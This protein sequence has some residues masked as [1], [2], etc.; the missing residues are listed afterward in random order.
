VSR[1][2][3]IACLCFST[4]W[5]VM[6]AENSSKVLRRPLDLP[7]GGARG[8]HEEEENAL[9]AIFFFGDTYE[10]DGFFFLL[11]RSGSMS[12]FKLAML[13]TEMNSALSELSPTSEFGIVSFSGDYSVFSPTPSRAT[14]GM[15]AA[16]QAWVNAMEAA[17]STMMLQAAQQLMP[18]VEISSRRDRRVIAVGDGSPNNPGHEETL[19]GILAANTQQ[20]PID[21]LLVGANEPA[22]LF[23]QQL[24]SDTGG[25]FRQISY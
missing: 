25:P 9:E 17:G 7:S 12:G 8:E 20:L 21:T 19:A 11:D 13:K 3:L 22:L 6:G 10:G 23:M 14:S 1:T 15:V 16:A 5:I 24:A 18:I 4:C 2:S